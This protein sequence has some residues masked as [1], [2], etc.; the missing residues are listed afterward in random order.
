[1]KKFEA[2]LDDI[3]VAIVCLL[4]ALM[5]GTI[6]IQGIFYPSKPIVTISE[7]RLL[8]IRVDDDSEYHL[9]AVNKVSGRVVSLHDLKADGYVQDKLSIHYR[10]ISSPT[11]SITQI[12]GR[13]SDSPY[14]VELPINY[15]IEIFND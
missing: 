3:L 4:G 10:N 15:K 5:I 1:M 9:T 7:Y 14:D 11:L 2:S 8:S 6:A 13:E 12:D